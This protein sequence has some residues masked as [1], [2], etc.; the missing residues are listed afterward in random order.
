[1]VFA[2]PDHDRD[3]RYK[4]E[5]LTEPSGEGSGLGDTER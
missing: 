3:C 4:R 2:Q 1:M 5:A